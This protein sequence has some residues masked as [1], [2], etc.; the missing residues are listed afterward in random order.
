[1]KTPEAMK[2]Y[3]PFYHRSDFGNYHT[4]AKISQGG[5]IELARNSNF[6]MN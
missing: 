3:G 6:E 5:L 1:M 4:V 2:K